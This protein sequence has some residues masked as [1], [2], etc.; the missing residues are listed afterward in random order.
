MIWLSDRLF[1]RRIIWIPTIIS[2]RSADVS[3]WP[4]V[5]T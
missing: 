5:I 1:F 3:W 2:L 4:E